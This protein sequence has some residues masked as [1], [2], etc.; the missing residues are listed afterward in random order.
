MGQGQRAFRRRKR[1]ESDDPA[2]SDI[3]LSFETLAKRWDLNFD[4][5]DHSIELRNDPG[6]AI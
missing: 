4:N 3:L 5:P 2:E 1:R 6:A